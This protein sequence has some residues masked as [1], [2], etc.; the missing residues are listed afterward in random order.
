MLCLL[1]FGDSINWFVYLRQALALHDSLGHK[2][3]S[4]EIRFWES[5]AKS[6]NRINA[7]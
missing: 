3:V 2:V 1:I 6:T 4:V 7:T 5:L